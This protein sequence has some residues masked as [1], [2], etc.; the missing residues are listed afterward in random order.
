MQMQFR[1]LQKKHGRSVRTKQGR[2]RRQH[3][4]DAESHVHQISSGSLPSALAELSHLELERP[5]L[6][7]SKLL[8]REV[9]EQS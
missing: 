2:K 1:L 6:D 9:V 3:L 4:A 8:H 7:S 5:S